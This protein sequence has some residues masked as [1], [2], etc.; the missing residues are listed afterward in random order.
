M[1]GSPGPDRAAVPN[2]DPSIRAA[3]TVV[4]LRRSSGGPT[5]LMGIR[6]RRAVFMPSKMVFP[7]GAVDPGDADVPVEVGPAL[8]AALRVESNGPSPRA[9]CAAAIRELWEETGLQL[10]RPGDWP[11]APPEW[12]GFAAGGHRPAAPFRFVFRAVTPPGRP[13]RFD[14]RFLLAD[15][16][17]L[18]GDPDDFSRADGELSHLEWVPLAE[19]RSRD[20][21][22]VTE[23][24]LAEVARIAAGEP[25]TEIPFLDNGAEEALLH[26]MRG[27]P[28]GPGD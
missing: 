13:R 3:S 20:I 15:A 8:A 16:D 7:G 21:P 18:A 9:L 26:R 5:V 14:A 11:D 24:A 4:L 28:S 23:L 25:R 27:H 19:A 10:S 12:R 2:S 1:N 22:F 6:S 17:A